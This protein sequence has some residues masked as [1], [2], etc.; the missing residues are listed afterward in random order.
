MLKLAL[1]IVVAVVRSAAIGQESAKDHR[2][3][4]GQNPLLIM[5]GI[6]PRGNGVWPQYWGFETSLRGHVT[7]TDVILPERPFGLATG[8]PAPEHSAAAETPAD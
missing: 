1:L 2:E 3:F 6:H 4:F 5:G 8:K 7:T